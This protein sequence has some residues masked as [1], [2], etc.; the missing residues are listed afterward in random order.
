MQEEARLRGS[1]PTKERQRLERLSD[2]LERTA[3][4]VNKTATALNAER[5]E[6]LRTAKKTA[7]ERRAAAQVAS[8]TT[9][10]DE[11]VT[12]VGSDTWRVLWQAARAFSETEA[13]NGHAFP[14]VGKDAR[15]V[16]C[17]QT[18]AEDAISRLDRFRA[19]MVD[20]TQRDAAAAEAAFAAGIDSVRRLDPMPVEVANWLSKLEEAEP[21]LTEATRA[22]LQ[23]ASTFQT[24]A[25]ANLS[26]EGGPPADLSAPPSSQLSEAVEQ[27]SKQATSIDDSGFDA[28]LED[29]V[30]KRHDLDGRIALSEHRTSI[31]AEITRLNQRDR[32]EVAKHA[33]D[34]GTI[35]RKATE[36][37]RSYVTNIVRDQFTRETDRLNLQRITLTDVGG[38]KGQ[39]RHKPA[40]LGAETAASV[41]DVLSEGEQTALGLAGYF[42]EAY[43]DE[44]KSA[45]VLD[46]PVTSLDHI[47]RAKAATRLATF[48]AE[49][50]VI[51]FTHDL[52]FV[53]DLRRAADHTSVA[54]VERAVEL[55]G[56][57]KPGVCVDQ[58]PWKARDV[59]ARLGELDR[60]VA[61]IKRERPNWS[62]DEYEEKCADWGGKLSE[63]WERMINVEVVNPVVDRGTSE[64]RPKMFRLFARITDADDREFQDSY[65]R[66]SQWARRHDKSAEVN[67]VAPQPEE[68][69]KELALARSWFERVS[70]YKN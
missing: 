6:E 36:L 11:P 51:V 27:R 28:Q 12:G 34:T 2:T 7:T 56:D 16:L 17:H 29:I 13:Y 67:Y 35:T 19:F 10:E 48:A 32:L 14:F 3:L 31:E 60:L 5:M 57:G 63:A 70:K 22:W 47:R 65:A 54:F 53:G 68:L 30:S 49:R 61:V 45:M 64:V 1:D 4:H 26:D 18:L 69:E 38:Y 58:H 8:S 43:F 39:L 52:S 42:T 21:D 40:L 9:F 33:A 37:T 55:R 15:C 23:A 59:K 41:D 50:Q 66:C 46:D 44:G 62:Q 25:V 20:Q 24:V